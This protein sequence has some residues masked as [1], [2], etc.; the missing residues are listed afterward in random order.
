MQQRRTR[1][2]LIVTSAF[3][4]LGAVA[5]AYWLLYASHYEQTDDAYVAGDLVNVSSQV[6]GTVVS[7]GAD[8]TDFVQMGQ[9][10]IRLDDT[11]ARIAL[12]EAENQL[13]KV[14]RQVRTVFT[15]RD[16]LSAVLAQRRADL[17]R[18]RTDL[19]RRKSLGKSGAVSAEEISHAQD[20]FNA[21]QQALIAAEKSLAGGTAL[22]GRTGVSDNPDV[23]AA[24]TAVQRAWLALRRTRIH[25]PVSGYIARRPAQ[26]GERTSS[27]NP[28]LSIVPLERLRVEANF[29]EVQL[30]RMR[31]GQPV[32]IEADLYGGRVEYRGTVAGLGLGTGAAFAL[33][34]AQNAT[35]NWIKVVQRV[36]VRV[37]LYPKD[38][39]AHPLRIGLSTRASVD[40]RNDSGPQ[41]AVVPRKEPVLSTDIYQID[42]SEVTARIA[43]IIADNVP[44][45]AVHAAPKVGTSGTSVRGTRLSANQ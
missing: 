31:I 24:A 32:R 15:S 26:L 29:K 14:V 11:D 35:G 23:Q 20:A 8:E 2:L 34:P 1:W 10:L 9:E 37:E 42:M 43:Q 19:E 21:A 45:E 41:L 6:S 7:I 33:L 40:I 25:A 36:P 39:A 4:V 17:S 22:L 28:L 38:L 30:S 27:G 16:E 12:T 18:A 13:A 3:V 5:A 44:P